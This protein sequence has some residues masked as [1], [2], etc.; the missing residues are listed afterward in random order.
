MS[1]P[2]DFQ[3]DETADHRRLRLNY[4]EPGSPWENPSVESCNGRVRDELLMP[5]HQSGSASQQEPCGW[6]T[7]WTQVA[8]LKTRSLPPLGRA[9]THLETMQVW[10]DEAWN[11]PRPL[12]RGHVARRP[13]GGEG[14]CRAWG[15]Q[16]RATLP[17]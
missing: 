17:W 9:V 7:T 1:G 3:F 12:C 6:R 8:H 13:L 16:A 11:L 5:A 10:A 2:L 4:M 15:G 14:D